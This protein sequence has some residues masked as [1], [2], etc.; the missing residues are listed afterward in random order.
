MVKTVGKHVVLTVL[1]TERTLDDAGIGFNNDWLLKAY[2]VRAECL[3]A[4]SKPRTAA[5]A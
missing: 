3:A 2:T 4:Q 5:V 1:L